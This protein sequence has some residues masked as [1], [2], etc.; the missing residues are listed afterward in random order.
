MF[1]DVLNL[2]DLCFILDFNGL[3]LN[4]YVMKDIRKYYFIKLNYKM[5]LI[6]FI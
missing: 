5:N 1:V 6:N 2:I 3:I 4:V